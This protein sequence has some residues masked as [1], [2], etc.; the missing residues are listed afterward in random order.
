[1]GS[2]LPFFMNALRFCRLLFTLYFIKASGFNFVPAD[3]RVANVIPIFKK[4]D[5]SLFGHYRPVSLTSVLCAK[6]W[7]L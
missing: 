5:R 4:G 3:W 1:M 6:L 2:I 7:N